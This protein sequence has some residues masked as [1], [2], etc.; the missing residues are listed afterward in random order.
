MAKASVD[1]VL[2]AAE[3]MLARPLLG[4]SKES[5]KTILYLRKFLV[6]GITG[7]FQSSNCLERDR[8]GDATWLRR[9]K[10]GNTK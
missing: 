5:R 9:G 3:H 4:Q 10:E 8:Q 6:W 1:A 2:Q 7:D